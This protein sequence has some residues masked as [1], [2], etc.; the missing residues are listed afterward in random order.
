[1]S[2]QIQLTAPLVDYLLSVSL[3]EETLLQELRE[4]MCRQTARGS[5]QIAPHQGQ[6]MR[7]LAELVKVRRGIEIATFTGYSALC[8]A[9]AMPSDGKL[10]CCDISEEWTAVARRYWEK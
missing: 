10:V 9:L 6:F 1:M 4:Q 5:M 3:R 2:R 7:L 8:T